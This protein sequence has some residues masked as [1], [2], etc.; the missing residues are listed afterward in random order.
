M[1]QEIWNRDACAES[2]VCRLH[3]HH[4]TGKFLN[5]TE[6]NRDE[7]NFLLCVQRIEEL[8]PGDLPYHQLAL[9]IFTYQKPRRGQNARN[10]TLFSPH[11]ICLDENDKPCAHIFPSC[12]AWEDVR[13]ELMALDQSAL[14]DFGIDVCMLLILFFFDLIF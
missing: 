7:L 6:C 9:V 8:T 12:A 3:W 2:A 1:L 10:V 5:R 13:G 4:Q 11:G 14:P